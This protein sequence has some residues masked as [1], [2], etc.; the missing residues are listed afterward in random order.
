MKRSKP[1]IS[2]LATATIVVI[3]YSYYTATQSSHIPGT[4]KLDKHYKVSAINPR[5]VFLLYT[6]PKKTS[7]TVVSS[8]IMEAYTRHGIPIANDVSPLEASIPGTFASIQHREF[9][10]ETVGNISKL[11]GKPV[12][13]VVSIREGS[14]WLWSHIGMAHSETREIGR[15]NSTESYAKRADICDRYSP[16]RAGPLVQESLDKYMKF[17]PV[18]KVTDGY[19][20]KSK[21]YA[22]KITYTPWNVIRQEHVVEDTCDLLKRL[23]ME[24]NRE[25]VFGQASRELV[26][27][28]KCKF[29]PDPSVVGNVNKINQILWGA[30]GEHHGIKRG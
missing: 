30:R 8:L 14:D 4:H 27:L 7:S 9:S 16:K 10:M 17:L 1:I 2:G 24:C 12:I 11:T 23:G 20:P 19:N 13:L 15:M 22:Y 28:D 29:T 18:Q 6:K 26:G 25:A 3:F 21:M 5:D